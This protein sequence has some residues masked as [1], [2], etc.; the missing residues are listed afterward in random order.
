MRKTIALASVMLLGASVPLTLPAQD[1]GGNMSRVFL[2]KVKHQH[3]EEFRDGLKAYFGCYGENGGE[4]SYSVY[5][6]ETGKLG[7]YAITTGDHKWAAFDEQEEASKACSETFGE[8]VVPH[9]DG[10]KSLFRRYMA[11]QSRVKEGEY[12]V[13]QVIDFK[14]DDSRRFVDAVTKITEAAEEADWGNFAWYDVHSSG[15]DAG[16]FHVVIPKKNFAGFDVGNKPLWE[17]VEDVHGKETAG[18]LRTDLMETVEKDW[19]NIWEKQPELSY[20]PEASE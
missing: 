16:N 18:K 20:S 2:V 6:A 12:N 15:G 17:M 7:R 1:D 3:G 4:K 5:S 8:K 9:M 10:A 13:F 11:E 19:S 14:V